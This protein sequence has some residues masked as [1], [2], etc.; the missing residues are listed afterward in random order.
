METIQSEAK[1]R[2]K[3]LKIKYWSWKISS[4]LFICEY[5][6]GEPQGEK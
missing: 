1:Q 4:S 2:E 3:K 5:S 6:L